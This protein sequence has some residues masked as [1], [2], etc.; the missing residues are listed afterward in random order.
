MIDIGISRR[1]I[2]NLLG[3]PPLDSMD[4]L[5]DP[6]IAGNIIVDH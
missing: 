1:L 2:I 3:T 4:H 6:D 5:I